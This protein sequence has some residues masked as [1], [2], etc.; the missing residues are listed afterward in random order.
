MEAHSTGATKQ[1]VVTLEVEL[2]GKCEVE[3]MIRQQ[4]TK[5]EAELQQKAEA[6]QLVN[7]SLREEQA[8]H[9]AVKQR[10]TECEAQS[11]ARVV[12]LV[13]DGK[14][15]SAWGQQVSLTVSSEWDQLANW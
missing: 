10:L 11:S 3:Q 13:T 12:Q 14:R 7:D 1:R 8:A 2:E 6:A 9:S 5:L 4:L 15:V